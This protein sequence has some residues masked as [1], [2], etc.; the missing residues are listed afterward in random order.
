MHAEMSEVYPMLYIL[1]ILAIFNDPHGRLCRVVACMV[2][3]L[4][5]VTLAIKTLVFA[6]AVFL[7][8]PQFNTC[9]FF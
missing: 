6:S 1:S 3:G 9:L 2:E 8:L 7:A 4:V 5:T